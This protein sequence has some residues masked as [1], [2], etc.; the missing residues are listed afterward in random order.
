LK[1]LESEVAAHNRLKKIGNLPVPNAHAYMLDDEHVAETAYILTDKVGGR[2]LYEAP[3]QGDQAAVYR[4]Q[5]GLA[6][7]RSMRFGVL[8]H[9]YS[10]RTSATFELGS[11]EIYNSNIM[12]DVRYLNQMRQTGLQISIR[13]ATFPNLACIASRMRW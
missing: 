6:N 4:T 9:R 2:P 11:S 10:V 8:G 1:R 5:E 7:F 13:W 12:D 3:R